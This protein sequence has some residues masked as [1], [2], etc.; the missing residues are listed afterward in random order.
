MFRSRIFDGHLPEKEKEKQI[1]QTVRIQNEIAGRSLQI[2]K[3]L[4]LIA[5]FLWPFWI[6]FDY[7]FAPS[8]WLEFLPIRIFFCLF[9][10]AFFLLVYRK[11]IGNRSAQ[12][13]FIIPPLLTV[14]Y[15]FNVVPE[16]ALYVY[17]LGA[18]MV[19][20]V[21][22]FFL[23]LPLK[24]GVFIGSF[25]ILSILI[26]NVLLNQ[27]T[28][29]QLVGNGG[30]VYLSLCLFGVG[31]SYVRFQSVTNSIKNELLLE[32]SNQKLQ[33][34]VEERN[35]LLQEV[36]HRVKNNLQIISS[37]VKLQEDQV[38][39]KTANEMLQLTQDRIRSLSIIHEC[40]YQ[41]DEFAFLD[42]ENYVDTLVDY[43]EKT[44]GLSEKGI[45]LTYEVRTK[46]LG[47]SQMVPCG[48]IINE[49]VTNSIKYAFDTIGQIHIRAESISGEVC[50]YITD[51]GKG[52]DEA[53]VNE[54]SLGIRLIKGLAL[55]LKGNVSFKTENGTQIL[56]KFREQ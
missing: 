43:L 28:L 56:V 11:K 2:T 1:V 52:F 44:Y 20:I 51:D 42:F 48:L 29:D 32:E 7:T 49:A 8:L 5:V 46:S 14:A 45:R 47:M 50:L 13:A 55:Q 23:I 10:L 24:H 40:L 18:T 34:M 9:S 33:A 6:L 37:L 16:E 4:L 36:H 26:V 22:F 31:L 25:A 15:M 53:Q 54:N 3:I 38:N 17:F 21:G 39:E 41:A 30:F 35:M 27:N 19:L 12:Y